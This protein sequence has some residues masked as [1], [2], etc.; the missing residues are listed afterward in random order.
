M[1]IP[2][3]THPAAVVFD[4][5]AAAQSR[6][7]ITLVGRLQNKKLDGRTQQNS[8]DCGQ[9]APDAKVESIGSDATLGQNGLRQAE[10]AQAAQLSGVV[11]TKLDGTAKGWLPIAVV[12]GRN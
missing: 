11:L 3:K 1:P 6:N 10:I 7:R 12:P 9:K 4:A 8:S 2:D 5:I